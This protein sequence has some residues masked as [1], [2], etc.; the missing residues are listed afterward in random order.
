ML[1]KDVDVCLRAIEYQPCDSLRNLW[2][3]PAGSGGIIASDCFAHI[4]N[5][6]LFEGSLL[7]GDGVTDS[8]GTNSCPPLN[9]D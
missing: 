2:M 3:L 1:T 8:F 5:D 9:N 6:N 4:Q 7:Q